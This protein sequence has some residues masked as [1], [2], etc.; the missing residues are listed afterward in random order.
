MTQS[1]K[2]FETRHSLLRRLKDFDDRGSWDEFFD[3]Y[4]KLIYDYALKAGLTPDEAQDV[5][6]ETMASVVGKIPDFQV[7]SRHGSFKSWLYQTT[8]WRIADQLRLRPPG[9]GDSRGEDGS[10][11]TSTIER[12]PDPAGLELDKVWN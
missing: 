9:S 3:R 1:N 4:W 6:Q 2:P 10:S 11:R 7:G 12:V 8:R 5:V